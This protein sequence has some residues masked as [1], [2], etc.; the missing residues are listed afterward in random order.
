MSEKTEP[1]SVERRTFSPP[2]ASCQYDNGSARQ[3]QQA[4]T[5]RPANAVAISK[6]WQSPDLR[7]SAL[8]PGRGI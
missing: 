7:Y 1:R 8:C 3:S 2:P 5:V 6:N 4:T